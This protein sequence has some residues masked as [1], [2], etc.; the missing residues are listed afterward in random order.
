MATFV[1]TTAGFGKKWAVRLAKEEG[2]EG[3]TTTGRLR[4]ASKNN[5]KRERQTNL[6][7]C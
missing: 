2:L 1:W 7:R 3:N 4:E 5:R 6:Y